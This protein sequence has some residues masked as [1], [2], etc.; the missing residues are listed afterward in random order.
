MKLKKISEPT[1][2]MCDELKLVGYRVLCAGE[3]YANEIPQ[4]SK[5]LV[6]RLQEIKNVKN[7]ELQYG[8]FIVDAKNEQEDGYWVMVE[9]ECFED[10]PN[11]MV[12]IVIPSQK[13]ATARY[14]GPNKGIFEA[15]EELHNWSA[16]QGYQRL[17]GKWH[18]EKFEAWHDPNKLVVELLD[19]IQ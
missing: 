1:A 18:V 4:A 5:R 19:T 13:Y 11:E 15:Y 17:T 12:T 2:K 6:N 16:E 3:K 14:E 7:S 8:V 10:I 9:V